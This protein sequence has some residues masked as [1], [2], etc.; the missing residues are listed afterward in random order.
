[1]NSSIPSAAVSHTPF[2]NLSV[3]VFAIIAEFLDIRDIQSL[4]LAGR[5]L[6]FLSGPYL[7]RTIT[8]APHQEDLDRLKKISQDGLLSH[9]T[10]TLRYDTT[11]LKVPDTLDDLDKIE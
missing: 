1:M 7:C 4:R 5:N 2:A 3:E 11:I 10:H 6:Y 9:H 8:F